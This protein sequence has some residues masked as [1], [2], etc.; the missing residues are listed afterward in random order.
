MQHLLTAEVRVIEVRV[1]RRGSSVGY[2]G[3]N[4][5][6]LSRHKR[7]M[8][9]YLFI[10]VPSQDVVTSLHCSFFSFFSLE[11]Q[12]TYV[13][14]YLIFCKVH[15]DVTLSFKDSLWTAVNAGIKKEVFVK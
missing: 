12:K 2:W 13:I 5:S 8:R 7:K 11:V 15:K 1:C 6:F 9:H 3:A 4:L 14:A 10:L